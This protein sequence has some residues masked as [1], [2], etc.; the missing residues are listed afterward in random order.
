VPVPI[1][2]YLGKFAPAQGAPA[3]ALFPLLPWL[4]YACFGAAYGSLLRSRS[5]ALDSIVVF[6]G[7]VGAALALAS[8]ESYAVVQRAIALQPWI[9]HP[10]RVLF[11]VGLVL[12]L[13]AIGWL[14][15]EHGRGRALI[16]YGRASLRIYWAHLMVAYGVLGSPWH[17]R[18]YLGEWGAR[19]ALL[20]VLMWLLA[21]LRPKARVPQAVQA[22]T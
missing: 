5:A 14:W 20:L 22:S 6:G 11:R 10:L 4:S 12:V 8:S 17:K 18:L 13:V 21:K 9:V 15:A 16:A 19:L 3:P 7:V 2:A 1:A